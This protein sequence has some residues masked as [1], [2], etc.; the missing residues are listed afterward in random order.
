MRILR[1]GV[2]LT[3]L[4]TAAVCQT[5]ADQ[6]LNLD[7]AVDRIIAQ[8][9]TLL[10]TLSNYTPLA[11]TYIQ[12]LSP[13]VELGLVPNRDHY[14]LSKAQVAAGVNEVRFGRKSSKLGGIFGKLKPSTGMQYNPVGFLQGMVID[15]GGFD[16]QHYDF[17]YVRREFLG[18]VRCMVLDV[19]PK[20]D[21][22][23][24]RFKGRIWAE[25]QDFNV[26]RVSGVRVGAPKFRYY[27]HFDTWRLNVGP[28]AWL[29]AYIYS[30][31]TD[32]KYSLFKHARLKAQTRLWGYELQRLNRQDELGTITVEAPTEVADRSETA[33]DLSP[34]QSVRAWQQQAEENVLEKLQ[35]AGLLAPT[36]E[37]EKVLST[38]VNNLIV[39]N[40]LDI[41]PEVRSRVLLTAPLES[42]T[43]GHTIVLSRGLID[44]LPDEAS[45]AMVLAHELGHISLGHKSD[46]SFAFHDRVLFSDEETFR[47]MSFAQNPDDEA[48][49]DKKALELLKNSPYKDKLGEGGLFLRAL[50]AR[51]KQVPNLVSAHL[52]NRLALG[53]QAVRMPEVLSAAPALDLNKPDQI[54]A[55]PLGARLKVDPWSNR[56]EM[57]KSKPVAGLA[58]RD[59]MLFEVTPFMPHLTRRPAAED[60]APAAEVSRTAA[61]QVTSQ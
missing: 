15:A 40:N 53:E 13:D 17:N 5:G 61:Q 30:E 2:V 28:G 21:S 23:A 59:K 46:T 31:E 7:Q 3:V 47:R 55:L 22:G 20:A 32:V 39:T 48:A 29:P 4:V 33:Q 6:A 14:F 12:E 37:V 34:I 35:R 57:M 43:I 44:V 58:A 1:L 52:G 54:A 19:T 60:T 24:G 26:V 51:A 50:A 38:V 16:R 49:A 8:E 42:F 56:L 18:D 11:E 25:D 10:S 41:Q 45:L 9:Q 27:F 36:G